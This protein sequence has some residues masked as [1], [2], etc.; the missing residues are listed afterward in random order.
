MVTGDDDEYSDGAYDDDD[1]ECD[2]DDDD[3]AYDDNV[4]AVSFG[5]VVWL[6]SVQSEEEH[7]EESRQNVQAEKQRINPQAFRWCRPRHCATHE[8]RLRNT[9]SRL[10]EITPRSPDPAFVA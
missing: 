5:C 1:D 8:C 4:L 10:P 7:T 6:F 9:T 2:S 3:D